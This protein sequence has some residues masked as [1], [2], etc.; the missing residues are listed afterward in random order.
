[1]TNETTQ[2]LVRRAEKE[3]ITYREAISQVLDELVDERPMGVDV[4]NE[5]D[6][7]ENLIA[8]SLPEGIQLSSI[9]C[10][11]AARNSLVVELTQRSP[12][13]I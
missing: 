10:A 2:L 7:R 1:M 8:H 9:V 12:E 6:R 5:I 13:I 3:G 11:V 4:A